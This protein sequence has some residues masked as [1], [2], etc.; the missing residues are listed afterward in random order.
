MQ[1]SKI[2]CI[3][4]LNSKTLVSDLFEALYTVKKNPRPFLKQPKAE[5][6]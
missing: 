6:E 1:N 5:L 2:I 4:E 3:I